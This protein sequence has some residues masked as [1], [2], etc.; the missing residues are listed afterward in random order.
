[1]RRTFRETWMK[2]A[3]HRL[4][5]HKI[6]EVTGGGEWAYARLSVLDCVRVSV[7]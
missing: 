7:R 1:M 3:E 6:I 4:F 5:M 2:S